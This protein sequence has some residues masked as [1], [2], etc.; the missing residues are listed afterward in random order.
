MAA[1]ILYLSEADVTSALTTIDGV[2]AVEAALIAHARGETLLPPE[3]AMRWTSPAGHLA[4]SLALP[5]SVRRESP[6]YGIKVINGS[7][8]NIERGLSRAS[9]LTMLFDPESAQITAVMAAAPISALRT[10]AVSYLSVR[11]FAHAGTRSAAMIGAGTLARAHLELFARR[12][13]QIKRYHLF[14]LDRERARRLEY[15]VR[16]CPQ[17]PGA[18]IELASS[19]EQAVREAD[20]VIPVTTTSEAYIKHDWLR[21][22]T[23]I[24]NVSLDDIEPEIVLRAGRIIVDDWALVANDTIRLFGRMARRGMLLG[25]GSGPTPAGARRVDSEL[26]SVLAGTTPIRSRADELIVVNPFGLG[27]EDVA[28]ADAVLAAARVEGLGTELNR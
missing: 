1:A 18:V 27:I 9:G 19:A 25:P 2:A 28:V 14:D 10:A 26:G 8:G 23:T 20:V 15:D 7:F 3:A 24:V 4:R 11:E 12:L 16:T 22:G 13:P 5:G 6:T 17:W 21:A